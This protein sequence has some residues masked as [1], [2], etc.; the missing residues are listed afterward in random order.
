MSWRS[1]L[2]TVARK[3]REYFPDRPLKETP[4]CAAD[5]KKA[6]DA[7][8]WFDRDDAAR[9]IVDDLSDENLAGL[10]D[11]TK[12]RLLSELRDGIMIKRESHAQRRLYESFGTDDA[13]ASLDAE[14][15]KE[16]AERIRN[17][18]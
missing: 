5:I 10:P 4:T 14:R 6:L 18:P 13:F 16:T 12:F 15:Q 3:I 9:Q 1:V 11:A 2:A 8:N 7:T 17:M